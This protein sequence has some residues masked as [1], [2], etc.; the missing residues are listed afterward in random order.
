MKRIRLLR[1]LVGPAGPYLTAHPGRPATLPGICPSAFPPP[2][3]VNVFGGA[4]A[5]G[6]PI[7]A[8]GTR[9]VVTLLN[10]L[11]CK[12]GRLG[13]AAI[14]NGGHPASCSALLLA[15]PLQ[16]T[17]WRVTR[18]RGRSR[19]RPAWADAAKCPV[20]GSSVVVSWPMCCLL[21]VQAA[22]A[23]RP[24]LWSAWMLCLTNE[25]RRPGPLACRPPIRA[26]RSSTGILVPGWARR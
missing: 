19:G 10:V 22:A 5:I 15:L 6:H 7:G 20:A 18:C 3:R 2:Y 11:R 25:G 26:R 14:C 4:V 9:L 1:S 21:L 13:V 17:G 23:P 12:G 24:W 8:S 16:R